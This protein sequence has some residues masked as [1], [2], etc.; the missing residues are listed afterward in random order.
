MI[1]GR[2]SKRIKQIGSQARKELEI[3]S[4]KPIFLDLHVETNKHWPEIML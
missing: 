1:I 3:I 4:N 2:N